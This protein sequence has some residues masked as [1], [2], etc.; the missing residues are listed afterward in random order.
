M[1][2][3]LNSH[4]HTT[5]NL[6]FAYLSEIFTKLSGRKEF[7]HSELAK[8]KSEMAKAFNA[9]MDGNLTMVKKKNRG[10]RPHRRDEEDS[11]MF[12]AR[13]SLLVTD[14]PPLNA[15]KK[16]MERVQIFDTASLSDAKWITTAKLFASFV[17]R[18]CGFWA[19]TTDMLLS[20]TEGGLVHQ[21]VANE[22]E[23]KTWQVQG[24]LLMK[25][26]TDDDEEDLEDNWIPETYLLEDLFTKSPFGMEHDDQPMM[27]AEMKLVRSNFTVHF[28]L[29]KRIF[30]HY[31]AGHE[32]VKNAK[33]KAKK[34]KEK[35]KGKKG[36]GGKNNAKKAAA[37]AAAAAAAAAGTM[38]R[39][40]LLTLISDTKILKKHKKYATNK[41]ITDAFNR[42]NKDLKADLKKAAIEAGITVEGDDSEEEGEEE[43]P[44]DE[45]NKFEFVS[46]L[47][48]LS[49]ICYG[50]R[51]PQDTLAEMFERF[52]A[53]DVRPNAM[54]ADA[55]IM[56]TALKDPVTQAI[57]KKHRRMLKRI[58]V[59]YAAAD[60]S[61]DAVKLNTTINLVELKQ[62][63]RD[64]NLFGSVSDRMLV[65]IFSSAQQGD[66][67]EEKSG[68]E[69]AEID[70]NEFQEFLLAFGLLLEP[71]PHSH[72]AKKIEN[73]IEL[74]ISRLRGS[75]HKR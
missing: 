9:V 24:N 56:V 23:S 8:K 52:I 46:V 66:D 27:E 10:R 65:S 4:K 55:N 43:N 50:Q 3:L 13:C 75:L 40:E 67:R 62:M 15:I 1:I 18:S 74:L 47:L 45:L 2:N 41:Q 32:E 12:F 60:S 61:D 14:A 57:L 5:E 64:A 48:R 73:F 34:E 70:A 44:D 49:V 36:K 53:S 21:H 7:E 69:D 63:C 20:R 37:E 6:R 42:A 59:K 51:Y 17:T 39:S 68:E 29:I 26:G 38:S 25:R 19:Q 71:D 30:N 22:L 35:E 72:Y 16:L 28:A 11:W 58:F 31:S 54:S 33:Q